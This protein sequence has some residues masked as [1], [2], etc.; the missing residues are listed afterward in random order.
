MMN[1]RR[2]GVRKVLSMFYLFIYFCI[3]QIRLDDL[4]DD[5]DDM[6]RDYL[7]YPNQEGSSTKKVS[8]S[9]KPF[10]LSFRAL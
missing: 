6:A 2:D 8:S 1:R 10:K 5:L 7:S 4:D 3:N 9:I